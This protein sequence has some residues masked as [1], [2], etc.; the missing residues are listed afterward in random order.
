MVAALLSLAAHN[1]ASPE[2][3]FAFGNGPH[4]RL[5][6]ATDPA[7]RITLM[8]KVNGKGPFPFTI[9]TGANRSVISDQLAAQLGLV[10]NGTVTIEGLVGPDEVNSVRVTHIKA[11]SVEQHEIDTAVL[12]ATSLGSTGFLGTDM[13]QGRNVVLDFRQHNITLTR[14]KGTDFDGETITVYARQR[15]GQLVMTDAAVGK[16]KVVAIID[17][18]AENTI[19]NPVLRKLLMGTR[20]QGPMGE[21]MGV[22]GK[23]IPGE[24]GKLPKIRIGKMELGGMPIVFADP[25]TFHLFKLDNTPAILVGMDMLRLFNRVAIDFGRSE[26]RFNIGELWNPGTRQ[27]LN[28]TRNEDLSDGSASLLARTDQ[29]GPGLDTSRDLLRH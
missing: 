8:T 21:L 29:A 2:N 15:L 19:G 22:T 27:A 16:V 3:N 9:D 11:G 6:T 7:G 4:E 5:A 12:P 20:P 26:V 18:G 10:S 28:R 14:G 1:L 24:A 23:T 25:H 17:T 13:L